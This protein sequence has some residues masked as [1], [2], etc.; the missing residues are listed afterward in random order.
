M[1]RRFL[2]WLMLTT[3]LFF[4]YLSFRPQVPLEQRAAQGP[5]AEQAAEAEQGAAG[6]GDADEARQVEPPA[7]A[8]E[9]AASKPD[10]PPRA[11]TLGSMDP[12]KGYNLL[13][14][15]TTR[16]AGVTHVEM[17]GHTSSGRLKFRALEHE[18]GGY[19]GYLGLTT[20]EQGLRITT[21]PDG[22]PAALATGPGAAGALQV[23]DELIEFNQTPLTSE[24]LL[25][26]MLE[27]TKP[28][29]QAE[30]TVLRRVNNQPQQLTYTVTL[31]E[32]PLDVVRL[33]PRYS[34]EVAGN[35][36]RVGLL[37]TLGSINGS[38]IKLGRQTLPTL[39]EAYELD[40]EV[41]PL[42]VEGGEG[43]EFRLPLESFLAGSGLPAKLELVKRYRLHPETPAN[44]GYLLD[45]ETLV[46]NRDESEVKLSFRQ[47]GLSG[48]TLEGWW[49]SVKISP[50]MFA[51]AGQRDVMYSTRAAGHSIATT[52]QIL[53]RARETASGEPVPPGSLTPEPPG[54]P[55][56]I[57]SE[58]EAPPARQLEY[59][60]IDTQYFNASL[61]PHPESPDD[62]TNLRAAGVL[63]LAN[64]DHIKKAKSQAANT[65]FWVDSEERLV[66]PGEEFAHRYHIFIGPKASDVLAAHGLE[67]AIEYGW[68]PWIAKP[69]G[70]I[71]HFF[72]FI[73][74]N[75]GLA[76]I[77]L[78]VMVRAAMFPLGR[79]AAMNAQRMQ[80]LQPEMKRINEMYKDSMEK[81]AKAMQELY[82][83]H[84]FKPLAGCLPMFIQLPIFIG[85]YRC[86]SVDISLRQEPLIPG[87][88]WCSNLAGPDQLL[89]WS[90]WM[91]EFLAGRGTGW[92]G[93]YLN[94]LPLVTVAL[95]LLQ[96]KI[97]MPKATDE[98]TRM[99]Q[100]MMQIMTVFMGVLFFKVPSGLC[101]YFI[102]SSIW[103]LIERKLVKRFTPA[104]T[105][106]A[107]A[108][109]AGSQPAD[110]DATT[111]SRPSSKRNK[112][113]EEPTAEKPVGRFQELK[114]MLEKPAVR[115]AT[116]RGPAK[117]NRP[118]RKDRKRR[119]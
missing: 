59:I 49:Y 97:L 38:G 42:E 93:P 10:N 112:R 45:L 6:R 89:N 17:V 95:F 23:G 73:V 61:L 86:L 91:P 119:R 27:E 18:A 3:A 82:A 101:I 41:H 15:L 88:A 53:D 12:A 108:T 44:D 22:S 115:S 76:I 16:G 77:L 74:R 78:T 110:N 28:G 104:T 35:L 34:E 111:S 47:E 9:Q 99:T 11:I 36:T 96:Q 70:H 68:F 94:I 118:N 5:E 66:A 40:W 92:L 72:H 75:Y 29:R 63:A 1:D 57:L 7:D 50:Y 116:Q 105:T 117:T 64:P 43:V 106:P 48:L 30:L 24:M 58:N 37:T 4:L 26:K 62:L 39:E 46:V 113:R 102:T 98:Q 55:M 60:G 54:L 85:L 31:S 87:V 84:N 83:K 56:L 69:L 2:A 51:G 25:D 79:K 107:L 67:R 8:D 52:R 19:L 109:G 90:T 65:T 33:N 13:V 71:L 20:S 32:A 80:E 103:S 114:Q 100:K 81:R 14:T 21:I